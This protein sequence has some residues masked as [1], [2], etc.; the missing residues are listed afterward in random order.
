MRIHVCLNWLINYDFDDN[1]GK[2][3]LSYE[4]K[5]STSFIAMWKMSLWCPIIKE[6][7]II[8]CIHVCPNWQT[9]I[10]SKENGGRKSFSYETKVSSHLSQR[11]EWVYGSQS[12]KERRLLCESV[13][14]QIDRRTLILKI[15][16]KRSFSYET[17]ASMLFIPIRRM[18][19]WCQSWTERRLLCELI[20]V[21]IDRQTLNL[22][23]MGK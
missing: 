23:E 15:G 1:G 3:S 13:L 8:M 21:P 4:A 10:N 19:L 11:G 9:N 22:K 6:K 20:F 12:W 5:A 17:K 14:I 7:E 18:S 16:G 2:K